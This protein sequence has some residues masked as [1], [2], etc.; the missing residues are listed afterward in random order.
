MSH[1]LQRIPK[2][3]KALTL[4][5][6]EH[7][8]QAVAG[9]LQVIYNSVLCAMRRSSSLMIQLLENMNVGRPEVPLWNSQVNRFHSDHILSAMI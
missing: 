8:S 7:T 4:D 5:I 3:L 1:R 9:L 6:F 2:L